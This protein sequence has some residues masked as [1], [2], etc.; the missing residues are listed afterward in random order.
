MV[1]LRGDLGL[2][3]PDF[4]L[5]PVEGVEWKRDRFVKFVENFGLEASELRIVVRAEATLPILPL[6]QRNSFRIFTIPGSRHGNLQTLKVGILQAKAINFQREQV[7][8]HHMVIDR[9]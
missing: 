2:D 4:R 9:P 1:A 5:Q 3:L 8:M 7:A 6:Y